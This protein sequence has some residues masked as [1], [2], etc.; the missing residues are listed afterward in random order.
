MRVLSIIP[1]R[2]GSKG[3]PNKNI[4]KINNK[5]L[6]GHTIE[7]SLKNKQIDHTLVSTD[8]SKIKKISERYGVKIPF[9]RPKKLSHDTSNVYDAVIYSLNKFEKISNLKF[10]IILILQPTSPL[11]KNIDIKNSIKLLSSNDYDSVISVTQYNGISP[12]IM[13]KSVKKGIELLENNKFYQRQ[14]YKKIFYRNGLIYAIKRNTLLKKKSLYGKN[15]GFIV[16]P[17]RRSIN[18]DNMSDLKI[19]KNYYK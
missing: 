8:S 4:L 12:Y 3:I 19:I 1:A 11:R 15:I 18:L 5:H 9:L 2:S 7:L 16:T 14:Q 10:D 6:I 17:E 13:Y